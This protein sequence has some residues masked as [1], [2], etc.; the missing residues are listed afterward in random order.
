M[1]KC[2]EITATELTNKLVAENKC[3][4]F[5]KNKYGARIIGIPGNTGNVYYWFEV[6]ESI[7]NLY[8]DHSYSCNTGKSFSRDNKKAWRIACNTLERT[9]NN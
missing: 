8:F 1:K 2:Y 5:E 9:F 4:L 7:D 3:I 6:L